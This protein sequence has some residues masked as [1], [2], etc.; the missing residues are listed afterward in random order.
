MSKCSYRV[1]RCDCA[2]Y[3]GE[4]AI[5]LNL[6]VSI[7]P[8]TFGHNEA[9]DEDLQQST[10]G[11]CDSKDELKSLFAEQVAHLPR[12]RTV[13]TAQEVRWRFVQAKALKALEDINEN[14]KEAL[15]CVPCGSNAGSQSGGGALPTNVQPRRLPD[16]SRSRGTSICQNCT[17]AWPHLFR[18]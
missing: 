8:D 7:D 11:V 9:A 2:G 6:Q 12:R 3:D 5:C 10:K 16:G 18:P 1:A 15:S 17:L 13:M 14:I 4:I